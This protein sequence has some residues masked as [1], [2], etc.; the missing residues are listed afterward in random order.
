M[1]NGSQDGNTPLLLA[2]D[3]GHAKMVET[4]RAFGASETLTDHVQ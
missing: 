1:T 2:A 3:M 4:L